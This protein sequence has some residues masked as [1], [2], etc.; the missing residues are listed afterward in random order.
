MHWK[1][2]RV[3]YWCAMLQWDPCFW[4]LRRWLTLIIQNAMYTR[5]YAAAATQGI[6]L[7]ALHHLLANLHFIV[8]HVVEVGC[9]GWIISTGRGLLCLHAGRVLTLIWP[10]VIWRAWVVQCAGYGQYV[11]FMLWCCMFEGLQM[12]RRAI[13]EGGN[14]SAS[15]AVVISRRGLVT[16]VAAAPTYHPKLRNPPMAALSR[17]LW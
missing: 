14:I 11:L 3:H 4:P 10:K 12:M 6:L 7:P 13:G 9:I 1:L 5:V 15:V 8:R 16:I 17:S 2:V